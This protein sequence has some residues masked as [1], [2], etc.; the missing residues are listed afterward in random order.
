MGEFGRGSSGPSPNEPMSWV[1][2][3][4]QKDFREEAEHDHEAKIAHETEH[5]RRRW[6]PSRRRSR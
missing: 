4:R 1:Q 3:Q 6:W 5:P 2:K